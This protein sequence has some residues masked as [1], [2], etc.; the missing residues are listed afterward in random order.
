MTVAAR[1][2]DISRA[3][4]ARKVFDLIKEN[5][6]ES[7]QKVKQIYEE[8][9]SILEECDDS[10]M[11]ALDQVCFKGNEELV[12]FLLRKGANADNRRHNQGYTCL[13]F[14][15]M[16][17]SARMCRMLLDAGARAY[18][19]NNINK[20]AS[21]IAAFIGKHECVSVISN[22]INIEEV[23]KIVHPKG[24]ESD[25]KFPPE[26]VSFI[27]RLVGT[28]EIHPVKLVF[29]IIKAEYM[30]KYRKKFEWVVDRMFEKQLRSKESNEVMSMK[31]WI[32]LFMLRELLKFTD[33]KLAE[34]PDL[35]LEA[36]FKSYARHLLKM[37]PTDQVRPMEESLLRSAVAAFPYKH[38]LLAQTLGKAISK[39]PFG[40]PPPAFMFINQSLFGQRLVATATF[41]A[42]CGGPAANLRCSK[43]KFPYCSQECQK[44]DW[45][46]HKQCCATLA[47]M[48]EKEEK[49]VPTEAL[50]QLS[51]GDEGEEKKIEEIKEE[52]AK[53]ADEPQS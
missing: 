48:R 51:V 13:M 50:I 53:D 15:A 42:T 20:T 26:F 22:H 17:G 29:N 30:M 27:H 40:K 41:C 38:S 3:E 12:E 10:G 23:E 11:T 25:E 8:D 16:S 36:V 21:E 44:F 31:L 37:K 7:T 52:E 39:T 5:S 1:E 45:P 24:D 2:R 14:A 35:E 46:I 32:L 33:E 4:K 9:L 34:K 28:H 18:A 43:C 49:E 19:T 6:E 47:T